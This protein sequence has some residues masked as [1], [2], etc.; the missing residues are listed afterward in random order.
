MKIKILM[1]LLLLG[2]VSPTSARMSLTDR[3]IME[4]NITNQLRF[5]SDLGGLQQ[6]FDMHRLKE[7]VEALKRSQRSMSVEEYLLILQLLQ[8]Q[9]EKIN[10]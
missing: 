1:F 2:L 4:D 7:E 3:L 5:Q 10:K 9:E 8:E 6:Q